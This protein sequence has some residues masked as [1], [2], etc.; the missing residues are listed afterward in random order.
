MRPDILIPL[1]A[2]LTTLPGIG[3][4]LV[5][6]FGRLLGRDMPRV[7]DLLFHMPSGFVDRRTRPLIAEALPDTDVTLEVRVEGHNSPPPGSRAPHRT[8]VSDD[9][10]EMTVIHFRMDDAR[11]AHMLPVGGN[12]LAVRQDHPA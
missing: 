11:L 3:P 2:P 6:P 12:T 7:V 4:K 9:S 5:R 8:Y 10:G 1:F